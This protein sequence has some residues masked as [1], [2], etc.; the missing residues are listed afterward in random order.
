MGLLLKYSRVGGLLRFSLGT[1][2]DGGFGETEG[3]RF[4]KHCCSLK[5]QDSGKVPPCH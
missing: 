3:W 2:K 1:Q 5:A 4:L